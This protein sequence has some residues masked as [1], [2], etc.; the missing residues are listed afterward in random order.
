MPDE[1]DAGGGEPTNGEGWAWPDYGW[2]V[3]AYLA[4]L[5]G[6]EAADELTGEVLADLAE[7]EPADGY[8]ADPWALIETTRRAGLAW[9]ERDARRLGRHLSRRGCR[10]TPGLLAER[11]NGGVSGADLDR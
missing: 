9:L 3:D 11:T 7:A 2:A 10:T 8:A 6:R 4:H 1:Q 5:C